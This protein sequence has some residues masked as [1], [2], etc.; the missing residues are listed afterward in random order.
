MIYNGLRTKVDI[1]PHLKYS[2][3]KKVR[4]RRSDYY[5]FVIIKQKLQVQIYHRNVTN[6]PR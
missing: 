2:E 4:A 3:C 6:A 5:Y 1:I